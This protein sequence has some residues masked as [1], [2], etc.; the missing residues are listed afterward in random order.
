MRECHPVRGCR[1]TGAGAR[2]DSASKASQASKG[3]EKQTGKAG[4]QRGVAL[5]T[6]K[7]R[8]AQFVV[9]ERTLEPTMPI[10][11]EAHHENE[12]RGSVL[13]IDLRLRTPV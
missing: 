13:N 12:V 11:E 2:P 8:H 10:E 5:G 9:R 4:K 3:A 6:E 7:G 1:H